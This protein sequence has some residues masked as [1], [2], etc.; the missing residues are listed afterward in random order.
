MF[1]S[2]RRDDL[3]RVRA[4]RD[5]YGEK[6][7]ETV[8]HFKA[9]IFSQKRNRY[10]DAA[11]E[12]QNSPQTMVNLGTDAL[13]VGDFVYLNGDMA[14]RYSVETRE[15]KRALGLTVAYIYGLK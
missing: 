2:I 1:N 3:A 15:Q 6:T 8:E 11:G 14:T 4:T 10:L 13:V 12:G 9:H 5:Q 7:G